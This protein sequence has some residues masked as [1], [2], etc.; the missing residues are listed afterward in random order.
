MTW[1]IQSIVA[2]DIGEIEQAAVYFEMGYKVFA[3]PPFYTWH[4][5]FTSN[6][7]LL[8]AKATA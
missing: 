2:L 5:E 4:G 1:G 3:R 7:P 6:P 8:L